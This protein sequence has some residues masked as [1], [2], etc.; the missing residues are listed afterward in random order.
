[1][2]QVLTMVNK[3]IMVMNKASINPTKKKQILARLAST[4][5]LNTLVSITNLE[6]AFNSILI[7]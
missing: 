5:T 4:K 3:F 1:M 2:D 7:I 6:I